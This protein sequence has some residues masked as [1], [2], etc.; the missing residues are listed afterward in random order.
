MLASF[1]EEAQIRNRNSKREGRLGETEKGLESVKSTPEGTLA[2]RMVNIGLYLP[3]NPNIC[4][5][6]FRNTRSAC[7]RG[8][9]T[10]NSTTKFE[11]TQTSLDSDSGNDQC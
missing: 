6:N 3:T 1:E 4:K 9:S 2:G 8:A 10:R 5:G 11:Q 7:W